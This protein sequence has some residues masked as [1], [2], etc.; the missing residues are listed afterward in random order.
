MATSFGQDLNDPELGQKLQDFFAAGGTFKELKDM[1]DNTMEAIYQVAYNLYQYGKYD[2]AI[3][4]FRFLGFFDHYNKKYFMG[5]GACLQMLKQYKEAIDAYSFAALLDINDPKPPLYAGECHLV[6]GNLDEAQSGFTA[7][8]E[9]AEK[10]GNAAIKVKAQKLLT[11]V[12]EK[13][14]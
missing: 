6:L 11:A 9:F 14:N 13:L 3:K 10:A 7:A 4:I 2:E 12:Q 8:S 1:D 5:L